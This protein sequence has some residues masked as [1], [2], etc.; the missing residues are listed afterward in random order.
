MAKRIT[1]EEF[2]ERFYR[3]YPEAKIEIIEYT[4]ISKPAT[5]RCL[6][7]NKILKRKIARQFLNGFDCCNAHTL[8]KLDKVKN[9]YE[10]SQDFE[11]VKSIDK[12]NIIIKHLTCGNK[13]K[14]GISSCLDNPYSCIHCGTHKINNQLSK[15]EIQSRLNKSFDNMIEVLEYNGFEGQSY[16]KCLKC[17]FIFKQKYHCLIESRGCPKC[18][19]WQSKGE[20]Y[21]AKYLQERNIKFQEQYSVKE[22]PLQRFDFA[23]LDENNNP[24]AFIEV[25]GEGH[26][27]QVSIFDDYK[28]QQERDERKRKYCEKYNIPLYELIYL[29]GQFKNLEIL[30]FQ[31]NDYP[32]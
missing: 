16:F 24:T 13:I 5:I 25:Q 11:F 8:S 9:F 30:P 14:R 32:R 10:K 18:D 3:N 15:D 12:D 23:I 22:L 31:F 28:K 2:L 19:R 7:C 6:I 26:F 20:R 27:R 21:I 29:K 1:Q 4:A 17:G